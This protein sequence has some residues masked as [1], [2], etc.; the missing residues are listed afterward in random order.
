MTPA[1]GVSDTVRHMDGLVEGFEIRVYRVN[2]VSV[3]M[4]GSVKELRGQ[5]L[6]GG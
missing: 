6:K 5:R 4:C 3:P 1:R 2:G